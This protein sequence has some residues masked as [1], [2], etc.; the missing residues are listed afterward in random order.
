MSQHFYY[1]I[2][3]DAD[4]C[5]ALG[6]ALSYWVFKC[7]DRAKSP[8]MGTKTWTFL[9]TSIQN[10]AEVSTSTEDYLQR[11]STALVAHLRPSVL[12]DIVQPKQRVIRVNQD[13]SEM[14]E[15]VGDEKLVFVG[16]HDLLADIAQDGFSEWDV[17][18][19]CRTKATIVQVLCRLRFEEDRALG[20]DTPDEILD[21]EAIN[22]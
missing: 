4:R 11:L 14:Q 22:V 2:S 5:Y 17:L 9:E 15:L 13:M 12:T 20:Q 10:S 21:V 3:N 6:A 18:E 8:A 19:V 16:W 1:G 7:R